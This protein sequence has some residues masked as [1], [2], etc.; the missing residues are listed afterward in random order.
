MNELDDRGPNRDSG[1]RPPPVPNPVGDRRHSIRK[2]TISGDPALQ[3][4]LENLFIEKIAL[5]QGQPVSIHL[6]P[7][8]LLGF[9]TGPFGFQEPVKGF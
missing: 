1:N 7:H 2:G 5:Y 9:E 8:H 4:S 6:P 3:P